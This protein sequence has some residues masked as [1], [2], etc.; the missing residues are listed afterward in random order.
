[1]P[2][3]LASL[4]LQASA[5]FT[6]MLAGIFL[7]EHITARQATGIAVAVLGLA[8]IA[9]YRSQV[10]ALLPVILTLAGALGWALGNICSREA[11]APKPMQLT[12]WMAVVPPI[13]MLA[14]SL[15]FDG[16]HR[17]ARSF[18]T[19][20]SWS[21]WGSVLALLYI[22]VIAAMVGYGIWNTLLSR[23]PSSQVAPFA[24]LVPVIGVLSSWVAFGESISLVEVVAGAAV[25][26]GVLYGSRPP[27]QRSA[28]PEQE[29]D[30][31]TADAVTDNRVS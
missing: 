27:R 21:A 5:P 1:M 24:M 16:P 4:V 3:G 25:I 7:R 22:A 11:R 23:N 18:A 13:P 8:A 19:L 6:V 30:P 31:M 14:L 15:I 26:G 29:E 28:E 9:F 20:T 12:M 17:I 2:S 10:A